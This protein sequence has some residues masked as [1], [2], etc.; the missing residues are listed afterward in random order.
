MLTSSFFFSF[1]RDDPST[2]NRLLP[3]PSR[4]RSCA[5]KEKAMRILMG[6]SQN[7]YN[8]HRS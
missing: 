5:Q 1:T 2:L 3:K 7:D 4:A 6:S 8:D